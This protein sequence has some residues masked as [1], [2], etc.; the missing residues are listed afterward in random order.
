M[1]RKLLGGFR[2]MYDLFGTTIATAFFDSLAVPHL[3]EERSVIV[4]RDVSSFI[5]VISYVYLSMNVD[6][7][8]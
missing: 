8:T 2:F 4:R 6:I 5:N 7:Y 3:E 1:D